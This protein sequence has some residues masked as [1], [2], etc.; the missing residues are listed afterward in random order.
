MLSNYIKLALRHLAKYRLYAFINT[1]GLAIGLT[2][3]IFS[4]LLVNY[5]N[6]HDGMFAERDRI[7][8]LNSIFAPT[9]GEPISEYTDIRTTYGPLVD[10]E[11]TGIE[12]VAR[13]I[14]EPHLLSTV[15][16]NYYKGVRF[17]DP[18]FTHIF[19]F[20][21][22]HG[23]ETAI[24][25][26]RGLIITASV[27]ET[28]FGGTDVMG[29]KIFLDHKLEMRVAGVIEDVPANSHFNS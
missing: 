16:G 20:Q 15:N 28:L 19:D 12:Q 5:E 9:S 22:L 4:T 24:D 10:Q 8:T 18:G 3:F 11:I 17:A 26:P 6:N 23:D 2:V 13:V 1:A 29:K 7:F 25:D 14:N 21:Y 27:A